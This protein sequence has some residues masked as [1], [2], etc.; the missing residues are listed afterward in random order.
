[1]RYEADDWCAGPHVL[2]PE[3]RGRL[4][5]LVE[6]SPIIVEHWFYRGGSSPE[7]F[8]FDSSSDLGEFLE[9]KCRPGDSLWFWR[10][11][12]ACRNDNACANGKVP[13]ASGQA[14]KGGVY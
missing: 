1:M 3:L 5:A 11:D 14:P 4:I 13:D 10:F 6:E 2:T 12:Q 7:R 8:V 9:G